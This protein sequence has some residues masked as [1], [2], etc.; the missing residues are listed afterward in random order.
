MLE[1]FE[2]LPTKAKELILNNI[3]DIDDEILELILLDSINCD[4]PIEIILETAIHIKSQ[5]SLFIEPQCEIKT[6]NK[7]YIADF[8]IYGDEYI[9]SFLKKDFQLIIECDG[10]EFHQ[11]SKKQVYYDNKREYDIKMENYE[12]LRFSGSKIYNE[13][14]KC[15]EEILNYIKEKNE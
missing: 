9:N 14:L 10:Y 8:C 13:P 4:S 7:T 15:A 1:S 5:G 11:K 3:K 6:K 2:D 12:I